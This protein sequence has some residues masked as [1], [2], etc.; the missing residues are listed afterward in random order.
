MATF[1]RY[2]ARGIVTLAFGVAPEVVVLGTIAVAA[3][4]LCFPPVRELVKQ[5]LWPVL[6][7]SLEILPA[8]LGEDLPYVAGICVALEASS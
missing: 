8:D 6:S 3:G 1:N 2:L 7:D 4:D 5:Q